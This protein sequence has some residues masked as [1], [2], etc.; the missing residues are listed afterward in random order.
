MHMYAY[1]YVPILFTVLYQLLVQFSELKAA[2]LGGFLALLT[3][4][5]LSGIYLVGVEGK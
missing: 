2:V 1:I 4:C 5:L 3:A